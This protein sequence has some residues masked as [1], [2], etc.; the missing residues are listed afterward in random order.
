MRNYRYRPQ[1]FHHQA[2]YHIVESY[3]INKNLTSDGFQVLRLLF[4]TF[5][6]VCLM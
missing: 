3:G 5:R 2:M 6:T 1:S 4:F